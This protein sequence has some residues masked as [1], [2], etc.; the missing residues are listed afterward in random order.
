MP[1]IATKHKQMKLE[2]HIF[3]TQKKTQKQINLS[4]L[5][6]HAKNSTTS[7]LKSLAKTQPG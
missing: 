6:I 3:I 4:E 7:K 5:C 2:S 1:T